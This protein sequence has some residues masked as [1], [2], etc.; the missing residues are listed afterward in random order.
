MISLI[1]EK[2]ED[3]VLWGS[4]FFSSI[5]CSGGFFCSAAKTSILPQKN[6]SWVQTFCPKWTKQFFPTY[7]KKSKI[8]V[9]ILPK[10]TLMIQ[11]GSGSEYAA[12]YFQKPAEK[13]INGW[14]VHQKLS[15]KIRYISWSQR[16]RDLFSFVISKRNTVENFF[17]C[18][19]DLFE[20]E[21]STQFWS[22][23]TYFDIIL[24]IF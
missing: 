21:F 6:F 15:I 12:K 24:H 14:F 4:M 9:K 5:R 11:F 23:G 3:Y 20:T 10:Y 8:W 16:C 22:F 18:V 13:A 1:W 7:R 2:I 19:I 17:V